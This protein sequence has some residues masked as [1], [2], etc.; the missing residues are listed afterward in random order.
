MVG[1]SDDG[2]NTIIINPQVSLLGLKLQESVIAD[3]LISL[4]TCVCVSQRRAHGGASFPGLHL[5][6]TNASGYVLLYIGV[7]GC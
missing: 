1:R 5:G 6:L 3:Q 4:F 7:E 2:L